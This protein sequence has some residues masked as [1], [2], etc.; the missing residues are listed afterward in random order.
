MTSLTLLRGCPRCQWLLSWMNN[1]HFS[2][3]LPLLGG[4]LHRPKGVYY[5]TWGLDIRWYSCWGSVVRA[6]FDVRINTWSACAGWTRMPQSDLRAASVVL[7]V[8]FSSAIVLRQDSSR[9]GWGIRGVIHSSHTHILNAHTSLTGLSSLLSQAS[10]VLSVS[11]KRKKARER[12][13]GRMSGVGWEGRGW[14]GKVDNKWL[15]IPV[16]SEIIRQAAPLDSIGSI[17]GGS[18]RLQ[19]L[20]LPPCTFHLLPPSVFLIVS[21]SSHPLVASPQ[22]P[23]PHRLPL[24]STLPLSIPLPPWGL[25]QWVGSSLSV[26]WWLHLEQMWCSA[27]V[28]LLSSITPLHISPSLSLSIS[29]PPLHI[30]PSPP[31]SISLCLPSNVSYVLIYMSFC[32]PRRRCS[33]NWRV[34]FYVWF[35]DLFFFLSTLTSLTNS[36]HFSSLP[37]AAVNVQSI[38]GFLYNNKSGVCPCLSASWMPTVTL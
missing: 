10:L 3:S 6:M 8:V 18:N 13:G 23:P 15:E 4:P 35:S 19:E 21:F 9:G 17:C 5:K 34:S 20:F 30:S 38:L 24:R 27:A 28:A 26:C 11:L 22:P 12:D 25:P 32:S 14:E 37:H 7:Y 1:V 16:P 36:F 33:V 31:L 2:G 29:L